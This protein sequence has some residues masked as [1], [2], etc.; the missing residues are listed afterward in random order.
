MGAMKLQLILKS[1]KYALKKY[2]NIEKLKLKNDG[3]YAFSI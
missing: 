3:Q 1:L 2:G